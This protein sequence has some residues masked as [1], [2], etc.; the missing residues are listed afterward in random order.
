MGFVKGNYIPDTEEIIDNA[1]KSAKREA[2]QKHR[3]ANK[4]QL[5]KG[6]E[7][8]RIIVSSSKVI[9]VYEGIVKKF[10]SLGKLDDFY[11]F[12]LKNSLN[13]A[14][15]RKALGHLNASAKMIS[16]MKS[17]YLLTVDK[18]PY[19][20]SGQT[21]NEFYGRLKSIVKKTKTSLVIIRE[22][23]KI[24]ATIPAVKK[25]PTILLVGLPNAGK[26]TLLKNITGSNVEIRDYSFTTKQLQLGYLEHKYLKF[27][28]VDSPGLLDR[29]ESKQNAIEKQTVIAL[30]HLADFLLFVIDVTQPIKQ[31]KNLI[32][33][34][35]LEGHKEIV[36]FNKID[37][38]DVLD[39]AEYKKDFFVNL[40]VTDKIAFEIDQK[41]VGV[42]EE[43]IL[44][45]IKDSI[46]KENKRFYQKE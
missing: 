46:Y 26:S 39:F 3:D 33:K 25:L 31:Q 35:S 17:R 15:L 8:K 19:T 36:L 9:G 29:P 20:L 38:L 12:M 45:E 14:K 21:R 28:L 34:F 7:K 13:Y 6:K 10:P 18:R 23:Y 37:S 1:F 43:K 22:S 30:K 44:L 4:E 5:I 42:D 2:E 32:K 16:D 41:T 40:D 24:I 27:Q 11:G